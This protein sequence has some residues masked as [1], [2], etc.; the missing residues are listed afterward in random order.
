MDISFAKIKQNPLNINYTKDDF[1]LIGVL[2]RIDR[3]CIKLKTIFSVSIEV[4]CNRCG[5]D[6]LIDTKYPLELIL[7]DGRYIAPKI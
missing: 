1:S 7:S 6:F 2:E 5:K 4:V 3:D